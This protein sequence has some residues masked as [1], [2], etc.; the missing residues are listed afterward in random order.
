M[1]LVEDYERITLSEIKR[2]VMEVIFSL[3]E[4]VSIV[5]ERRA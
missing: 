5:S 4:R 1:L 2:K 3:A